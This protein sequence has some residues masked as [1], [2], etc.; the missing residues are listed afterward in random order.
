[1]KMNRG[2]SRVVVVSLLSG[3]LILGS[4]F[5]S[6]HSAQ[7]TVAVVS[8]APIVSTVTALTS[9]TA[10]A[11][12][13]G[14]TEPV[15]FSGPVVVT[16]TVVND[17]ALGPSVVVALDGR[18]LKATGGT[19]GTVY[20]NECEANLTRPFGATDVIKTTFAFYEDK[21]GGY[22]NAKTAMVTLNLTYDTAT[23]ALTKV[24]GSVSTL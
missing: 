12:Q 21:P 10:P 24:I 17:P 13:T 11:L 2:L 1:M 5:I 7:A 4:L 23:M 9:G 6:S 15:T 22:L 19:T 20:I 8:T 16:S 3:V 18:G 14:L